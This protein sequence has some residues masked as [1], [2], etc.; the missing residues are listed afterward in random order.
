MNEVTVVIS[1]APG[2]RNTSKGWHW[3]R[4]HKERKRISK[5]VGWQ[6]KGCKLRPP[7]NLILFRRAWQR[8]DPTGVVE[9]A[10]PV[11][12]ALVEHG[13]IPSDDSSVIARMEWPEQEV[14]RKKPVKSELIVTLREV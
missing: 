5:E 8:M 6:V 10:K 1:P 12:D 13:V 14:S 3:S 2:N 4:Y 7:V 9:S 11:L